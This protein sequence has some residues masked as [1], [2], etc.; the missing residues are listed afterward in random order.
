MAKK[1]RD[2]PAVD[3]ELEA[4]VTRALEAGI[5]MSTVCREAQVDQ[6]TLWK[7]RNRKA[8][9]TMNNRQAVLDAVDELVREVGH[10]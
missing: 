4:A 6:S 7:W 8:S 2:T 9:P 10:D 1:R 3:H 5:S